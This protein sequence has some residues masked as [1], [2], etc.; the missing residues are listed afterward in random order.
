MSDKRTKSSI[1]R[2]R[3]G[4]QTL[5]QH[6]RNQM[7]KKRIITV[8]ILISSIIVVFYI[9]N[10]NLEMPKATKAVYIAP[11][12]NKT[13]PCD[14]HVPSCQAELQ[15]ILVQYVLD[16]KDGSYHAQNKA[17]T[18]NDGFFAVEVRTQNSYRIVMTTIID[19]VEYRGVTEFSTYPGSSDC[20]TDGQ[21]HKVS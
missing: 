8:S 15:N 19:G 20:I 4:I 13:H 18:G 2:R 5:E 17:T 6:K 7:R 3:K 12:V 10:L 21:L 9:V 14:T 11:Y 1:E 16:D